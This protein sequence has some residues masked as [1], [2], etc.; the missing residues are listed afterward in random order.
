MT[1]CSVWLSF[2]DENHLQVKTPQPGG[3]ERSSGE[4]PDPA[5]GR[6]LGRFSYERILLPE[7]LFSLSFSFLLCSQKTD[8][9]TSTCSGQLNPKKLRSDAGMVLQMT[10]MSTGKNVQKP[11]PLLNGFECAS[12]TL[13]LLVISI[14]MI[15]QK[16]L[17]TFSLFLI[18]L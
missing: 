18:L 15:I 17:I 2:Q 11:T 3:P 7:C 12:Y 1:V 16:L 13:H 4:K 8:G 9:A 14:L 10:P 6:S 5:A